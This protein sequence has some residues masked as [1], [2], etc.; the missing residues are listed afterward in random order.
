M[1]SLREV[2][3]TSLFKRLSRERSLRQLGVTLTKNLKGE[4]SP[5]T[6]QC[7]TSPSRRLKGE[8][9]LTLA[10]VLHLKDE[11]TKRG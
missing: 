5:G 4:R 8:R 11:V 10:S 6:A 2:S 3:V 9:S 7:V 1:R